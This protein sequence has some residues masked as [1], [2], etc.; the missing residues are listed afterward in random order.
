MHRIS[1]AAVLGL[2]FLLLDIGPA[3]AEGESGGEESAETATEAPEEDAQ[4]EGATAAAEGDPAAEAGGE[5]ENPDDEDLEGA[6]AP[7]APDGGVESAVE[8][9]QEP[10]SDSIDELK[11]RLEAVETQLNPPPSNRPLIPKL[12][13]RFGGRVQSDLRFRVQPVA[14]G[15][16]TVNCGSCFRLAVPQGRKFLLQC[17]LPG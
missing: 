15:G 10:T 11:A 6:E 4:G 3:A 1:V 9:L 7:E 8:V 13:L 16:Q 2:G 12:R 17:C 14:L 5:V